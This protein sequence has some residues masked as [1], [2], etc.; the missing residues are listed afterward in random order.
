[1]H[2]HF[3]FT[4]FAILWTLT[5]AGHLVLLVVLLGRDRAGRFPFFTANIVLVA[6]RLLTSWMLVNS[7]PQMAM[8]ELVIV[9]ADIAAVLGLLVVLELARR[10]F[11]GIRRG[12]WIAG[13]L[14]VMAIGALVLKFWGSWPA[15]KAITSGSTLQLAQLIAQKGSLLVDVETIVVGLLI[16]LFGYR[17]RGGW[18]THTQRIAIGLSTASIAELGVQAIWQAVARSAAPHSMAEYNQVVQFHERLFNA[19][20]A[21]YVLVLIWWIVCLWKDE[22]GAPRATPETALAAPAEEPPQSEADESIANPE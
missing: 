5:F 21:I 17:Q 14:A 6:F 22:P 9:T 18:R 20:S 15:W 16:V 12:A 4:A 10:A 7:L 19:N 11:G 13:T 8:M 2:F 3:P 1:M